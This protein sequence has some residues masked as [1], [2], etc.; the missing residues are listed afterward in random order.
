M[1]LRKQS[2]SGSDLLSQRAL[3]RALLAR[4]MLL[5]RAKIPVIEAIERL[6]GM[7]AQMPQAPSFG[8]WSRVAD[9]RPAEL[10]GLLLDRRVVRAPLM[11][12][13]VHLVTASDCLMMRPLVQSVLERC[14]GGTAFARH[15]A[16]IDR[17]EFLA[18][19]RVLLDE[20]PRQR[21]EIGLLLQERWPDV[22]ANSMA[23]A[24]SALIPAVQAPP[25][26][27]W[28]KS[29]QPLWTTV[30]KWLGQDL[31]AQPALE[32]LVCR[33]L[34]A[35]GPASVADIQAWCGLTWLG[36][37][38]E[39]LRPQLLT[40]HD[41]SGR[42]LFDLPDA[43]RPDPETPAPPR[44]LPEFDNLLLS[45]ADRTRVIADTHR[46]LVAIKGATL[47]DGFACGAWK[48]AR[49]GRVATLTIEPFGALEKQAQEALSEEG[50]RLLA[51]AEPEAASYDIVF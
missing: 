37:V 35:F 3:N 5:Q 6:A 23:C 24:V 1:A 20:G 48:I 32:T 45:H 4:Q 34:A 43:P 50:M 7:Q 28:K 25:R 36:A 2:K 30:E 8:L 44:F 47:I 38:V 42:E 27:L 33:Y 21:T 49:K 39:R 15:I 19:A 14:F 17:Q 51:F 16:Q 26:G 9:F 18:A 10:D 46:T 22:D 41:A 12:S 40:F 11:R 31:A 13:T 29:G